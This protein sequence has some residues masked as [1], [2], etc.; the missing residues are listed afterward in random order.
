MHLFAINL[1]H[2]AITTIVHSETQAVMAPNSLI[3]QCID[4]DE[5]NA[6]LQLG[7]YNAIAVLISYFFGACNPR[8][9]RF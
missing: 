2:Q 7:F 4:N 5:C 6:S 3:L 1:T 8:F 9:Q